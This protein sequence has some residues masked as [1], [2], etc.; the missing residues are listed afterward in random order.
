VGIPRV[1]LEMQTKVLWASAS[2]RILPGVMFSGPWSRH[3]RVCSR[4]TV[5]ACAGTAVV[6]VVAGLVG[7][8]VVASRTAHELDV[9]TLASRSC[10]VTEQVGGRTRVVVEPR[11][12][13]RCRLSVK[14]TNTSS[15]PVRVDRLVG[16]GLGAG[17]G[18]AVKAV[19]ANGIVPRTETPHGMLAS[20]YHVNRVVRP[21]HIQT[22]TMAIEYDSAG[23][24]TSG[25][26]ELGSWPS[27][28]VTALGRTE[29]I[30]SSNSL[31][32]RTTA[33]ADVGRTCHA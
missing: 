4:P 25:A 22:F 33:A 17:S 11:P 29:E 19:A 14:V 30:A 12:G 18:R 1:L 3:M 10:T 8:R 21:G 7:W 31:V 23:C 2:D 9:Q 16:Y 6:L 28:S 24:L 13:L 5:A 26:L 27:L 32:L 20:T 15:R